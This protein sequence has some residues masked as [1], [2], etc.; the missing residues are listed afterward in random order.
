MINN[1]T[2][3]KYFKNIFPERIGIELTEDVIAEILAK[4]NTIKP[5]RKI[6]NKNRNSEYFTFYIK[7]K[8][9]TIVADSK[10]KK[11]ITVVLEIR[12]RKNVKLKKKSINL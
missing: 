12:H 10:T 5:H 2:L 8:Y 4:C 7:D 11:L 3:T 9:V 1:Y 6:D